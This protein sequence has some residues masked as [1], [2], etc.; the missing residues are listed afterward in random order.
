M[1]AG[2]VRQIEKWLDGEAVKAGAGPRLLERYREVAREAGAYEGSVDVGS[3]WT[4]A[5][6]KSVAPPPDLV[7]LAPPAATG[8]APVESPKLGEALW[9]RA[10]FEK[11]TLHLALV[12]PARLRTAPLEGTRT[13]G[14][15][16][17]F[18][19]VRFFREAKR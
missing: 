6:L 11:E 19:D 18:E 5:L 15:T 16:N 14:S 3:A 1:R 13:G 2:D 7:E 10:R 17:V 8:A 4:G 9:V 12:F